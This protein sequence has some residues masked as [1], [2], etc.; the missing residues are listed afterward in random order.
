[1]LVGRAG[2]PEAI[3]DVKTEKQKVWWEEAM[4]VEFMRSQVEIYGEFL[5]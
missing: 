3:L 5:N 1:M 2:F 4:I